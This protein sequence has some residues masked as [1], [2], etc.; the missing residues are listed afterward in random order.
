[1]PDGFGVFPTVVRADPLLKIKA[2]MPTAR[3][4]KRENRK[5]LYE[6]RCPIH[7]RKAKAA[8]SWGRRG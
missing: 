1:M 8:G 2:F 4:G 7:V 5:S 3:C 6:W